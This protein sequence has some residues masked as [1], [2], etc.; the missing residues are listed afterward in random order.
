[1]I[2]VLSGCR[3]N[4]NYNNLFTGL[5][6]FLNIAAGSRA[7][8]IALVRRWCR[9]LGD[10]HVRAACPQYIDMAGAGR[11]CLGVRCPAA[12]LLDNDLLWVL[13]PVAVAAPGRPPCTQ[14]RRALQDASAVGWEP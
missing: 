12:R 7:A 13:G 10:L 2:H 9:G 4:W 14:R 8:V 3:G 5:L 11:R 6:H 1:M